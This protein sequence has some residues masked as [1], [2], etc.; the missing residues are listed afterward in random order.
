MNQHTHDHDSKCEHNEEES[1]SKHFSIV[2][3]AFA[4]YEIFSVFELKQLEQNFQKLESK[5]KKF[6][7]KYENNFK[8][9][10]KGILCNYNFFLKMLYPHLQDEDE[11]IFNFLT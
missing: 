11:V 7:P 5:F 1:D 9:H 10:F 3:S 4:D 8:I 2:V 6:I